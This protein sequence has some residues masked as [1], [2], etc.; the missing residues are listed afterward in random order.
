MIK[1]VV[2]VIFLAIFICLFLHP[3]D[4]DGDFYQHVNIGK[5]IL[6]NGQL[7]RTDDLTFTAF[8][9]EYIGYSLLS[10]TIFFFL[11]KTIGPAGISL[12]VLF[13]AFVTFYLIYKYLNLLNIKQSVNLVTLAL[14]A[15]LASLRFPSRP[16]IFMYPIIISLLIINILKE[17]HPKIVFAYPLLLL[18]LVLCYSNSFPF[19]ALLLLWILIYQKLKLTKLNR[20]FLFLTLSVFASIG[21]AFFNGYGY[22]SLFFMFLVPQMTNVWGDWAGIL[23]LVNPS[24]VHNFPMF[25]VY[26]YLIFTA[27]FLILAILNFKT[28]KNHLFHA[29][30][31]LSIFAPFF[32]IRL[33]T[34]A[35]FL[36]SPMLAI[37]FNKIF[38]KSKILPYLLIFTS[39]S[40]SLFLIGKNP[41]A[42]GANDQLYP[43]SL[44][45]FFRKY[46]L[47]GKVF[48]TQRLG[49]YLSYHLSPQIK[50]FSDTRD[51][52]FVGT[53]VLE[54]LEKFLNTK[55][56]LP[57]LLAK[58]QAD[59]AV[60]SLEDGPAIRGLF[61][62]PI[63]TA[64]YSQNNYY[65]FAK[66]SQASKLGLPQLN[67]S[68]PFVE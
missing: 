47:E 17:K 55:A 29:M 2:F 54:E 64:V 45:E 9:K 58:Y 10:G 52:L 40:I 57:A 7:P 38:P 4:P 32:A 53:G 30:L 25:I 5:F 24:Y 8:G 51:D 12:F 20:N 59:Y 6:E 63:W 49:S 21:L 28:F 14:A 35:I 66:R 65:I 48:N 3:I 18:L 1:K 34:L 67:L 13:L 19:A 68:D 62:H 50:V 33:R 61:Y 60:I 41:P 16:E 42:I 44:V 15:P 27:I 31:S 39:F 43:M 23:Q 11:L 37:I 22:K 36:I 56:S 46:S 26:L